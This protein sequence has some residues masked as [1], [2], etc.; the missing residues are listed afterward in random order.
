[1]IKI[2]WDIFKT[3]LATAYR[4]CTEKKL[5]Q[6]LFLLDSIYTRLEKGER[7]VKLFLEFHSLE[8]DFLFEDVWYDNE[9]G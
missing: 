8:F 5:L 9:I 4:Y 2:D 1:M 3:Q 6:S 7:T